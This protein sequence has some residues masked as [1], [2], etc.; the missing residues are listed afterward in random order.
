MLELI[1]SWRKVTGVGLW[2]NP[3]LH[4]RN[5][6]SR[7]SLVRSGATDVSIGAT[8]PSVERIIGG[9]RYS[10]VGQLDGDAN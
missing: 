2:D 8:I 6:L 3:K 5:K 10:C 7:E 4:E 1:I 9:G